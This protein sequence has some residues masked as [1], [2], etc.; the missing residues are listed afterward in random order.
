[1]RNSVL[2]VLLGVASLISLPSRAE[3]IGAAVSVERD[4]THEYGK[5]TAKLVEGDKLNQEEFIVTR[6]ASS[7]KLRFLDETQLIVGPTSRVKLDRFVYNPDNTGVALGIEF[8]RGGF[9]FVTGKSDHKAYLLKTPQATIAVRGTI[10]GI[11][12]SNGKTIVKLKE[13]GATV[14]MRNKGAPRCSEMEE[15]E[16]TVEVTAKNIS[17]AGLRRSRG[18][19]FSIWCSARQANCGLTPPK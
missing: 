16:T 7:T 4:V 1:M 5:A 6:I 14:C 2:I 9:R 8:L 19:D 13:G 15:L 18:P 3:P 10:I 12:V 17:E 11:F